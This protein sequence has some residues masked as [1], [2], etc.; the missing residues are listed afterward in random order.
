MQQAI[1]GESMTTYQFEV[2]DELWKSWKLTVPRDKSLDERIRELLEADRDG[3]V[4]DAGE[5]RD[6]PPEPDTSPEPD[7]EPRRREPTPTRDREQLR[8]ALAGDGDLLEA[9]VDAVLAMRDVLREQKRAT[10]DEL[11]A[12]VDPEVVDYADLE[13]VWSNMAKGTFGELDGVESPPPGKSEWR[14]VGED[15]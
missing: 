13:S 11:V 15:G 4:Q 12:V 6:E 8:D 3:R 2:D 7:P 5:K 10:K 14:W 9:R 1:D